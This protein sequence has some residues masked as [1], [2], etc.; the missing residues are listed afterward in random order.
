MAISECPGRETCPAA[1]ISLIVEN[2][3]RT[4]ADLGFRFARGLRGQNNGEP[5]LSTPDIQPA[6]PG[7]ICSKLGFRFWGE[8]RPGLT[9]IAEWKT[10]LRRFAARLWGLSEY[11]F[12]VAELDFLDSETLCGCPWKQ[13]PSSVHLLFS[14]RLGLQRF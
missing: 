13:N 3:G 12:I 14:F 4:L 1:D 8:A 10:M 7:C 5:Q 11:G 9:G 6:A 2:H